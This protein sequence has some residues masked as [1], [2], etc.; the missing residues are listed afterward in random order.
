M[1]VG[2][3]RVLL[4]A[5]GLLGGLRE[6]RSRDWGSQRGLV[7]LTVDPIAPNFAA[8]RRVSSNADRA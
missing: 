7:A 6:A 1:R 2:L 5:S 8:F 4:A 3:R